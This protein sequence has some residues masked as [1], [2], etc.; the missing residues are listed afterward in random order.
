MAYKKNKPLD[1]D[2]LK[3]PDE[4]MVLN[5]KLMTW[6]IEHKIMVIAVVVVILVIAA[7][8]SGLKYAGYKKELN[9]SE[10]TAQAINAYAAQLEAGD[11]DAFANAQVNFE[12]I[13][14]AYGG[15]A[16]GSYARVVFANIA[17]QAKEYATALQNY[18]KALG[19][20]AD[21]V[22]KSGLQNSIGHCYAA[23]GQNDKALAAF[24][25][26]AQN[27]QGVLQ[28]DALFNMSAVYSALGDNQKAEQA[29]AQIGEKYAGGIYG[30]LVE[31]RP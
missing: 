15:T 29:L 28:D 31:N 9:A 26:T 27:P 16:N 8:F 10:F 30:K 3:Q 5:T 6:I 13:I 19:F 4:F 20:Y 24:E 12:K 11:E 17:Y 23:L 2:A 25:K 22:I 7:A 14:K 18:E 1:K 21:P